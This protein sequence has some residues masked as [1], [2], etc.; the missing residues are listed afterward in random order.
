MELDYA[1]EAKTNNQ[2]IVSVLKKMN[3]SSIK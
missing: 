3:F 1:G 2:F